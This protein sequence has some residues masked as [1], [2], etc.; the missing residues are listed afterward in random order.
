VGLAEKVMSLTFRRKKNLH[1]FQDVFLVK[2]GVFD[3]CSAHSKAVLDD[4]SITVDT[5]S[6]DQRASKLHESRNS[7][8][9]LSTL[10]VVISL[11]MSNPCIP[12][13]HVFFAWLAN[14]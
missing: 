14:I 13:I 5:T 1:M 12:D 6:L 7:R 11:T 4:S 9:E 8:I 10:L 3:E 2:K